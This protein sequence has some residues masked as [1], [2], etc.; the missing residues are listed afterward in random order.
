MYQEGELNTVTMVHG[1]LSVLMDGI[2]MEKKLDISATLWDTI[3][4]IIV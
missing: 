1:T 2:P 4:H 3:T